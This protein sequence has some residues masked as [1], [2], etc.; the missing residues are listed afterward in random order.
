MW[1]WDYNIYLG[2]NSDTQHVGFATDANLFL[3]A[4]AEGLDESAFH[5]DVE[6]LKQHILSQNPQSL[7]GFQEALNDS[8]GRLEGALS[9]FTAAWIVGKVAYFVTKG[10]GEV[11]VSRGG[12]TAKMISGDTSSSG[13][14]EE[15][16]Y[17]LLTNKPFSHA[18]KEERIKKLLHSHTPQENVET[19]TPEL[20]A[21]NDVGMFAL[22]MK[23]S[24]SEEEEEDSEDEESVG[25][26]SHMKIEVSDDEENDQ[27]GEDSSDSFKPAIAPTHT[28]SEL[29]MQQPAT[30][31]RHTP[32]E[33]SMESFSYSQRP[34]SSHNK[35]KTMVT[36]LN[37]RFSAGQTVWKRVTLLI[38]ILL[39]CVL[40]WSV[41]S[42]NTRRQRGKFI[43]KVQAESMVIDGKLTEAQDLIGS[44]TERS[45]ELIDS[46]KAS[47]ALLQKEATEKDIKDVPAL[48]DLDKKIASVENS[49]QK[50][51]L[52]QSE[53][54]YDLDL[55]KKGT[56]A[57]KL[58]L[59]DDKLALLD[60]KNGFI[61][62]LTLNEKSV[63]TFTAKK[64]INADFVALHQG[65]PY[66]AGDAIGVIKVTTD[67]K[68]EEIIPA[69]K[70]WGSLTDFWMYSGNIYMLDSAKNDIHKYL[71]AENGYSEKR[72]YFGKGESPGLTSASAIAIDSSL[73]IA[74]S[75]KIQ[76]FSS[77]VRSPFD[78]T[79]PDTSDITFEDVFTSSDVD[80]VY[81]LDKDSKRVFI[82]SKTGE[83]LKQISAGVVGKADDFVVVDGTGILILAENKIYLLKE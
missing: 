2:D 42:G 30:P 81:I 32:S 9:S 39:V 71:V 6:I 23:V 44:N 64:A 3:I 63:E 10:D 70:D 41:F 27:K 13:F 19:L 65:I 49:I 17:F 60:N 57:S 59:D 83:F 54:F 79:I 51:E 68:G 15:S 52:A 5:E 18:V 7:S 1:S 82:I 62:V 77:G 35:F 55:I 38:V 80:N 34:L 66:I 46:S 16:D 36:S 48:S 25:V 76:K 72:S 14:I 53:E 20:K 75:D 78:V 21:S 56:K 73:Y 12:K 37:G 4:Q 47:L 11:F 8:W 61:Y 50:K 69:D 67:G 28:S 74:N 40:G 26:D 31:L 43:E 22:F 33:E 29:P 58:F 45:L 24:T